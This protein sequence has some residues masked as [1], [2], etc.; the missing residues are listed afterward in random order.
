MELNYEAELKQSLDSLLRDAAVTGYFTK[1]PKLIACILDGL[2]HEHQPLVDETASEMFEVVIGAAWSAVMC[3]AD[4]IEKRQ[5]PFIDDADYEVCNEAGSCPCDQKGM[6]DQ[7]MQSLIK[8]HLRSEDKATTKAATDAA[9]DDTMR[10]LDTKRVDDDFDEL[11]ADLKRRPTE[12]EVSKMTG[13]ELW[14]AYYHDK[15]ISKEQFDRYYGR[16]VEWFARGANDACTSYEDDILTKPVVKPLQ[17]KYTDG[18]VSMMT[19][20]ERWYAYY[21]DG[22]LTK[23]QFDRYYGKG[24][25]RYS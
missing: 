3:Y 23:E 8:Q 11:F 2:L 14:F 6:T 7:E 16:G 17:G 19:D 22:K 12:A 15:T 21:G 13:T 24:G 18:M 20:T 10:H 1:Q 5:V 4:R 9:V 25:G